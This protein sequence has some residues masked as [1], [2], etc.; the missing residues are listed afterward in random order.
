MEYS[1]DNYMFKGE[2]DN[3]DLLPGDE[4]N[5]RVTL[6]L[7]QIDLK[8]FDTNKIIYE[9]DMFLEEMDYK[10]RYRRIGKISPKELNLNK[11]NYMNY[12]SD[13]SKKV[14][15]KIDDEETKAFIK[16]LFNINTG[17]MYIESYG[18]NIDYSSWKKVNNNTIRCNIEFSSDDNSGKIEPKLNIPYTNSLE[19]NFTYNESNKDFKAQVLY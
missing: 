17:K 11:G 16:P 13:I 15:V 1:K 12:S 4:R 2:Y 18:A 5:I 3:L 19:I 7:R 14:Y 6:P 8:V 9:L 10:N